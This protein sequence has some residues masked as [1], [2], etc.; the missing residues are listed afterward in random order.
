MPRARAGL[1]LFA[2]ILVPGYL[3][4]Y[5]RTSPLFE[6]VMASYHATTSQKYIQSLSL[7]GARSISASPMDVIRGNRSD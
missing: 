3:F 2:A 7:S 6:Q 5:D 4:A 1:L